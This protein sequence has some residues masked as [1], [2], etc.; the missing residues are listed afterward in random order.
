[1]NQ[2]WLRRGIGLAGI[3]AFSGGC[4]G[5]S[6]DSTLQD[7]LNASG[8]G[9]TTIG[10]VLSAIVGFS[11]HA[12]NLPFGQTLTD[13]QNAELTA[14]QEQYTAGAITLEEYTSRAAEILGP[15]GPG[16]P[17]MGPGIMGAGRPHNGGF[18]ADG[19]GFLPG[20]GRPGMQR[21]ADSL[22]LTTDQQ[23]RA[24]A[25][26]EAMRTDILALQDAALADV[27]AVLTGEQRAMLDAIDVDPHG[28]HA[29]AFGPAL[30][31]DWIAEQLGLT[32]EQ[33]TAIDGTLNALR[34]AVEARRDQALGE[35]EAILTE[36]QLAQLAER[37]IG[38]GPM[39]GPMQGAGPRFD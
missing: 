27:D 9:T 13:E 20:G 11:G 31:S 21:P 15:M 38:R 33:Q 17:G 29:R 30:T 37:P 14:L 39:R 36:E 1:M 8:L 2:R 19:M 5:I 35:F 24:E 4:T 26:F 6:E 7:L 32:A 28:G 18:G 25:I 34:D 23:A 3:A 22:N 10:E 16:G 12:A